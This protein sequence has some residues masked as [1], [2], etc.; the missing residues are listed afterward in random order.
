VE[1]EKS[2]MCGT[3]E[4]GSIRKKADKLFLPFQR[5]HSSSEF[6]G[7]GIGLATVQRI[8]ARHGGRVWAE[9]KVEQGATFYFAL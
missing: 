9:S 6:P 8:I 4:P 1:E 3:A 7:T 2:T 5:L